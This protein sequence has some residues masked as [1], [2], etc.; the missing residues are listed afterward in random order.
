MRNL[1]A[2]KNH[3]TRNYSVPAPDDIKF[4]VPGK[5]THQQQN[6]LIAMHRLA[7][8]MLQK[9]ILQQYPEFLKAFLVTLRNTVQ[10]APMV[11]RLLS[12]THTQGA[13]LQ[14]TTLVDCCTHQSP[15][16]LSTG[17]EQSIQVLIAGVRAINIRYRLIVNLNGLHIV[18]IITQY[19]L[20]NGQ[21]LHLCYLRQDNQSTVCKSL[22]RVHTFLVLIIVGRKDSHQILGCQAI[23]F[24]F[25]IGRHTVVYQQRAVKEPVAMVIHEIAL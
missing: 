21:H 15:Y 24:V 5:K 22:M 8:M 12:L 13:H 16:Q 6:L 3:S 11:H 25:V 20:H 18:A 17:T 1:T 7:V 19:L 10:I 2:L 14:G 23:L 4:N 9:H